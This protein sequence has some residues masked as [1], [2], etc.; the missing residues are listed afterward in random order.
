MHISGSDVNPVTHTLLLDTRIHVVVLPGGRT[1]FNVFPVENQSF[2]P[3][4]AM[5][6]WACCDIHYRDNAWFMRTD[7]V[8]SPATQLGKSL[9]ENGDNVCKPAAQTLCKVLH[10]PIFRLS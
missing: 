5:L 7:S 9:L 3:A 6:L 4:R 2:A 10:N 8:V 1:V